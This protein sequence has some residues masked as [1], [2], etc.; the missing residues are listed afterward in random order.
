[1]RVELCVDCDRLRGSGDMGPST[2]DD[3]PLTLGRAL[4]GSKEGSSRIKR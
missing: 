1:M 2:R 3:L 4:R